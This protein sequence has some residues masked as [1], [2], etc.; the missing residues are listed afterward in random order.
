MLDYMQTESM[1]TEEIIRTAIHE[2]AETM[3]DKMSEQ[4]ENLIVIAP[5]KRQEIARTVVERIERM[6]DLN[7]QGET[8][9][10]IIRITI[11]N[12][13]NQI[14]DDTINDADFDDIA[15]D[16]L[17]AYPRNIRQEILYQTVLKA[18]GNVRS[19]LFPAF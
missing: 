11:R 15:I 4:V 19:M 9:R 10:E 13:V 3:I 7:V 14:I 12:I 2:V 18:L 16:F 17:D 6:N 1:T 5:E 8:A